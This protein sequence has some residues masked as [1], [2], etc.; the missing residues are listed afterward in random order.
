ML[1]LFRKRTSDQQ[2]VL[3]L[4]SRDEGTVESLEFYLNQQKFP[5]F[6]VLHVRP[7]SALR[8]L[9]GKLP[10]DLIA[11]ELDS[12]EAPDLAALQKLIEAREGRTPVIVISPDVDEAMVR[13][14]LRLRVSDWLRKPASPSDL[15]EACRRVDL[16]SSGTGGEAANCITFM[17]AMGGVGATS[18]AVNAAVLLSERNVKG[19]STTCLVDLDLSGGMCA[20]YLDLTPALHLDEIIPHPERLDDH[21]LGV[22]LSQY[23]PTLSLLSTRAKL[24]QYSDLDPALVARLLDL[25]ASRF[26][27]VVIDL[28]RAWQP[29]TETVLMGSTQFYVVTELT[30]PGLRAARR[31]VSEIAEREDADIV[32][33]RVIVN[34][35]VRRLLRTGIS[36]TEIK[37]VLKD[38]FAGHVRADPGLA[39][40]AIDR[41]VPMNRVKRRN[42]IDKDLGRIVLPR[43]K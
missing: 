2:P 3:L 34:K 17:G 19:K 5:P 38:S 21:L 30:V 12:A 13:M 27:N 6:Q 32:Q 40:E 9:E 25:V 18:L 10:A 35:Y 42:K 24:G 39:R 1:Q 20:E 23:S 28:P 31:L 29:W 37:E 14:F 16:A 7:E 41:G 4:V 43:K 8:H 11:V 36:N 15:V 33:P 26:A 22:M